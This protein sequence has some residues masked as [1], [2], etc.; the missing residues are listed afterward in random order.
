MTDQK[1]EF[2][3]KVNKDDFAKVVDQCHRIKENA[4]EYV[5]QL[6]NYR[7]NQVERLGLNNQAF[8]K[9]LALDKLEPVKRMDFYR[10]ILQYGLAR[11]HFDQLDAFDDFNTVLENILDLGTTEPVTGSDNVHVLNSVAAQ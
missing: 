5:G 11:G 1:T 8:S 3:Q 9:H 2:E 10:S 7:R 4:Q 6:G